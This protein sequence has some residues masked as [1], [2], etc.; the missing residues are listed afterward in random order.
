M[1]LGLHSARAPSYQNPKPCLQSP[2]AEHGVQPPLL[3]VPRPVWHSRDGSGGDPSDA[4]SPLPPWGLLPPPSLPPN[5]TPGLDMGWPPLEPVV[6]PLPYM[7]RAPRP[8]DLSVPLPP[9][10]PTFRDDGTKSFAL[11]PG[12]LGLDSGQRPI[13]PAGS[14][15]R[16]RMGRT[17]PQPVYRT[18]AAISSSN[19]LPPFISAGPAPGSQQRP[20]RR[21][22]PAS[23]PVLQEYAH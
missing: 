6:C 3:L 11:T 13:D 5:S 20:P 17:S 21:S 18:R 9:P 16:A 12:L 4:L 19:L 1:P 22:L 2:P 10:A 8:G 7:A 15:P 23:G 14:G